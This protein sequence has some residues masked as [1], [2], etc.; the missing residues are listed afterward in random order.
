MKD[1]N[2]NGPE[3]KK[4]KS[5]VYYF[6]KVKGMSHADAVKRAESGGNDNKTPTQTVSK[7][8]ERV[9]AKQKEQVRPMELGGC[10]F[11]DIKFLMQKGTETKP[12]PATLNSCPS[13][14]VRFYCA[15]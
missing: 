9:L 14:K 5:R 8:K 3:S 10:P 2:D 13:C 4:F 11:C 6:E 1:I 12:I 15:G 7:W